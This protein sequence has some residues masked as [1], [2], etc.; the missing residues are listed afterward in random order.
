MLGRSRCARPVRPRGRHARFRGNVAAP[1]VRRE[2]RGDAPRPRRPCRGGC[3]PNSHDPAGARRALHHRDRG[4]RFPGCGARFA[5]GHH[6]RHWAQGGPDHALEPRH[7]LSPAPPC[8]ARRGLPAR[9]TAR[10][11]AAVP[12]PGRPSVA[13]GPDGARGVRRSGEKSPSAARSGRARA[14]RADRYAWLARGASRRGL[15]DRRLAPAGGGLAVR[16]PPRPTSVHEIQRGVA[17]QPPPSGESKWSLAEPA[18][19]S[20]PSVLK[21]S[22]DVRPMDAESS[23]GYTPV[24]ALLGVADRR[25][26][27]RCKVTLRDSKPT[28]PRS[29]AHMRLVADPAWRVARLREGQLARDPAP[30]VGHA[31]RRETERR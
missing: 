4:C 30:H 5:Q 12:P 21:S 19:R 26:L 13:R 20:R 24:S 15:C 22:S 23:P 14:T 25:L 31:R 6:I 2:P 17:N 27:Q 10:R 9:S 1:G 29:A 11:R 16:G 8:R 7:A 18:P 28:E 3:G